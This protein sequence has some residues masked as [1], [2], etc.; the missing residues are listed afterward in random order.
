MAISDAVLAQINDAE[1]ALTAARSAD[2]DHVAAV[3]TLAVAQAAETSAAGHA[4][5]LHQIAGAKALAA[6]AALKAELGIVD[7][8]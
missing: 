1:D 3:S 5:D 2:A 6:I 8:P 4:L 7:P